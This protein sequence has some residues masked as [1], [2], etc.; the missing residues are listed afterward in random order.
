MKTPAISQCLL[1]TSNAVDS[2][3]VSD[4]CVSDWCGCE[5]VF[6]AGGG[7]DPKNLFRD[8]RM[9]H[10]PQ[11]FNN[12][13]FRALQWTR[14]SSNLMN[15]GPHLGYLLKVLGEPCRKRD[16]QY[17]IEW[18]ENKTIYAEESDRQ[19]AEVCLTS[20]GVQ[21]ITKRLRRHLPCILPTW[22]DILSL[23]EELDELDLPVK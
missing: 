19:S 23:T 14:G 9:G 7:G 10:D 1:I 13:C 18:G 5:D 6:A 4:D 12:L 17:Y 21:L 20:G 15:G 11:S 2:D 16:T 22:V 8:P 3:R